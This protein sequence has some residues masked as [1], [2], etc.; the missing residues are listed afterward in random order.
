M[1]DRWGLRGGVQYDTRLDNVA[2]VV[3]P[4]N[5][6]AMKTVWCS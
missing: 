2:T 6:V 5:T 1:T 4:L 3:R